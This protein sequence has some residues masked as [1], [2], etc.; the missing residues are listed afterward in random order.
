MGINATL[1]NSVHSAKSNGS[2]SNSADYFSAANIKRDRSATIKFGSKNVFRYIEPEF[3]LNMD[4]RISGIASAKLINGNTPTLDQADDI[5]NR[6]FVYLAEG[7]EKLSKQKVNYDD[8][9]AYIPE[10]GKY[11]S[12]SF[13][14]SVYELSRLYI[15]AIGATKESKDK[16][17]SMRSLS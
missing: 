17:F 16:L 7:L 11:V 8:L 12:H 1:K 2:V 5:R 3:G 6:L 14:G 10:L 9:E 4:I 13:K 15:S